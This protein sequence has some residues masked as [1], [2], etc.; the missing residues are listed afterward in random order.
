MLHRNYADAPAD[1]V[2]GQEMDESVVPSVCPSNGTVG[3]WT[4]IRFK[5]V[6]T[7]R[8]S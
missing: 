6:T 3:T 7:P 1:T 2:T 8:L 5:E 4:V